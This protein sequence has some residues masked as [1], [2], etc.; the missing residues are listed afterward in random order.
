MTSTIGADHCIG[1]ASVLA[2]IAAK[3][4]EDGCPLLWWARHK[5]S[6]K[7]SRIAAA[8]QIIGS[9]QRRCS[10]A[11]LLAPARKTLL[12]CALEVRDANDAVACNK[13]DGSM[14]CVCACVYPPLALGG[15]V[16]NSWRVH[17]G[18]HDAPPS[19]DA[20]FLPQRIVILAN[21]NAVRA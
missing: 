1:M 10:R 4:G 8:G 20:A 12:I 11:I 13:R 16:N 2:N 7:A 14:K 21:P 5:P 15:Q 9:H 3:V 19:P 18:A 17:R 6:L